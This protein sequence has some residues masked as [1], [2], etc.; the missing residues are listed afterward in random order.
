MSLCKQQ[1]ILEKEKGLFELVLGR[2][3]GQGLIWA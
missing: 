1:S 2:F 3:L